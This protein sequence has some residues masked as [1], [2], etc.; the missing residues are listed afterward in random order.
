MK[1]KLSF[2]VFALAACTVFAH[3]QTAEFVPGEVL[4]KFTNSSASAGA[5][6][7]NALI[8][9]S[10]IREIEGIGVGVIRSGKPL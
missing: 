2:G 8:G 4:V 3:G 1:V 5:V 7:A 6:G 9:A 10:V